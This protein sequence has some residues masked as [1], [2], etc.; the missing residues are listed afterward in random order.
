MI[1]LFELNK[2]IDTKIN[3]I[4]P[5][6][7]KPLKGSFKWVL[8]GSSGAGKSTLIK[9]VLFNKD[10]GYNAYF[11][12]IYCFISSEDDYQDVNA[13]VKKYK[14]TNKVG[15]FKK[16][17]NEVV[18][19]I[20]EDIESEISNDREPPKVLFIFDDQIC[21]GLSH[22]TRLNSIDNIFIKGRHA[23]VSCILSTQKYKA[24]NLNVRTLNTTNLFVF[25]S[26]SASDLNSIAEEHCNTLSKE[27][28]VQLMKSQFAKSKYNF[29][30]IDYG[31]DAHDRF[32]DSN[33]DVIPISEE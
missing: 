5:K 12:E 7:P 10:W 2:S 33:F 28:T 9:N 11:S 25:P 27:Q 31:G 16:F 15:M 13:M 30:Q 23:K 14:M 18:T 19:E 4:N 26:T 21:H 22:K 20:F 1:K 8:C 32:K 29:V 24:L 6:L 17:C 3:V